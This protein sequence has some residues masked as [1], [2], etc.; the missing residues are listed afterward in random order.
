M[1]TDRAHTLGIDNQAFSCR[2]TGRPLWS[3]LPLL[4]RFRGKQNI[5]ISGDKVII[6]FGIEI[7]LA[8]AF[9]LRA[10]AMP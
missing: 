6:K 8:L 7:G 5:L 9:G 3:H 2:Q 4:L 10:A 1:T